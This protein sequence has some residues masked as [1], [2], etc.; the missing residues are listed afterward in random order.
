MKKLLICSAVLLQSLCAGIYA[1]QNFSGGTGTESDPYLI[2]TARQLAGLA[3]NVNNGTNYSGVY[4]LQT[5][6]LDMSMY[7]WDAIGTYTVKI[8]SS[9]NTAT[10][11]INIIVQDYENLMFEV[12]YESER[13]YLEYSN[14]GPIGNMKM[15]FDQSF[16]PYFI[17]YFGKTDLSNMTQ[18]TISG[19]TAYEEMLYYSDKVTPITDLDNLVLNIMTDTDGTLTGIVGGKYVLVYA[20]VEGM[21]FAVYFIFEDRPPYPMTFYFDTDKDN[22]ITENDTQISLKVDL[23]EFGT[24]VIDLGD[25]FVGESGPSIEVTSE[26]LG[27]AE[28][29]TSVS[30]TVKWSQ[31]F[32]DYS[33]YYFTSMPEGQDMPELTGP[34]EDN[35][36]STFTLIFADDGSGRLV[37]TIYVCS[38]GATQENFMELIVPVTF[39]LVD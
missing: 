19:N 21:D 15:K 14:N 27:M 13:L 33:Y 36:T 24:G 38:A 22:E 17:G 29:E 8:F 10:R 34:S 20:K 26:E 3:Y 39:I 5:A 31:V 37:A 1:Q 16:I 30:V 2:S 32:G 23:D 7:W 35:L 25:F 6:D 9:D 18:V 28:T 11:S 12:F 4:F